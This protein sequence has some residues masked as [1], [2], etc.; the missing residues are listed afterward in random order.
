[1]DFIP[2]YYRVM[3]DGTRFFL[4]L[5]WH[6][7]AQTRRAIDRQ[8]S[9]LLDASRCLIRNDLAGRGGSEWDKRVHACLPGFSPR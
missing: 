8:R 5:G 2:G 6:M 3:I 9:K 7:S 4:P 1:M